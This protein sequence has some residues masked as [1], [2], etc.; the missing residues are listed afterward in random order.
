MR[1]KLIDLIQVME[2]QQHETNHFNQG[3]KQTHISWRQQTKIIKL[4]LV[5]SE[6]VLS[7]QC[8][9]FTQSGDLAANDQ[10]FLTCEVK[11]TG[12]ILYFSYC[13]LIQSNT[14]IQHN[15]SPSLNILTSHP[16]CGTQPQSHYFLLKT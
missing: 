12:A 3:H 4:H 1:C 11:I 13:Q 16:V 9:R 7:L 10:P 14:K 8:C 2:L 5:W 15:I 6:L